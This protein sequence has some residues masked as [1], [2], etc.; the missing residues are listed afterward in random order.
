MQQK[1]IQ[2]VTFPK[3]IF[4]APCAQMKRTHAMPLEI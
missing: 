1:E 4:C 2:Y 3:L